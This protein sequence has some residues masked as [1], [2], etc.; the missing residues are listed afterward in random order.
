MT[1][2][3]LQIEILN[4][5]SSILSDA[6]AA[7]S[8]DID[9]YGDLFADKLSLIAI[10]R[11]GIPYTL[12]ELIQLYTPFDEKDW[13]EIL[14]ISVKSMQRYRKDQRVFK[15]IQSEKIIE[16]TEVTHIGLDVFDHI[17]D[18]KLWLNTPS[19]ALG[20]RKPIDLLH[21]SY[22]KELVIA[23]LTRIDQGIFV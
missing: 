15:P 11:N 3:S 9:T 18:F 2:Q 12:F 22:G 21:D 10:I 23:E 8:S 16:M 20:Q 7:S 6:Q 14:G 17:D 19:F 13:S 5:F 1:P 4:G